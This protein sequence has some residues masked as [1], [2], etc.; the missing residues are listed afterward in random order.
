MIE[1]LIVFLI[2]GGTAAA[3]WLMYRSENPD[4]A[5]EIDSPRQSEEVGE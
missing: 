1:T 5:E 4:D 3:I 2:A